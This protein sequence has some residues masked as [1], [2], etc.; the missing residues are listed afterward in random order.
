MK[1]SKEGFGA[2]PEELLKAINGK[3]TGV[4]VIL[5]EKQME[6]RMKL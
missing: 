4:V 1:L 6:W 2:K 5:Y 3:T